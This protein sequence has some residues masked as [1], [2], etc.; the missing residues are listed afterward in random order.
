MTMAFFAVLF[1]THA[2]SQIQLHSRFVMI[3]LQPKRKRL[4]EMRLGFIQ[5]VLHGHTAEQKVVVSALTRPQLRWLDAFQPFYRVVHPLQAQIG[6]G[7]HQTHASQGWPT[8][9]PPTSRVMPTA[10]PQLPCVYNNT[11]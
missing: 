6:K 1:G 3:L 7:K 11:V 5:I 4:P 2:H 9:Q 10:A 8:R